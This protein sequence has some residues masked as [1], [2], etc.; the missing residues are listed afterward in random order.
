MRKYKY[1]WNLTHGHRAEGPDIQAIAAG[2]GVTG[3]TAELLANRGCAEFASAD[4]F[5]AKKEGLLHDPFLMRD[6]EP[7]A[8]RILKAVESGEK[9]VVY[10]DYDVDGVTSVSALLLYLKSI[11][12]NA[13]Y[14]I[15]NR[16]GEGYGMSENAVRN[17]ASDGV[18]LVVTVDTGITAVAEAALCRKLGMTLIV[19]DH[20]ECHSDMPDAYAVVN[21]HRP[22]CEY[23]FKELAGVGVVFKLLCALECLRSGDDMYTATKRI[24]ERYIDLVAIGTIADVMPLTDEN[25]LIVSEGLFRIQHTDR[26]GLEALMD[27]V[28]G[29]SKTKSSARK[30]TSGYISFSLA[31]RI[32]AAGRISSAG[33]AVSLFLENDRSRADSLAQ[34]LCEINRERQHE[35]NVIADSASAKIEA[36]AELRTS[37]VIVLDDDSWHHGIIGIVASRITEKYARPSILISFEGSVD[38]EP[39]GDDVGKG[40][41]RSVKGMNLVEALHSCSD[42]LEKYG[43]HELAAGLSVKRANLPALRERLSAFA[44]QLLGSEPQPPSLDYEMLITPSDVTMRQ[45]KELYLLEPFGVANPM[46]VFRMD[47]V[48]VTDLGTVG[49]GKHTKFTLKCGSEYVAAMCFRH[50]PEDYDVYPGD[51]VDVLFTLDVNEFQGHRSLQFIVKDL[52]LTESTYLRE[53]AEADKFSRIIDAFERG[54]AIPPELAHENIP[55]RDD[56]ASVYSLL[57]NELRMEHEQFSIRAL[58]NLMRSNGISVGYIKLRIAILILDEMQLIGAECIDPV[59]EAYKFSYIRTTEKRNLEDSRLMRALRAADV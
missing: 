59:L 18:S 36:S 14:Y 41:G 13:E 1:Q 39:S 20:H 31:P 3:T 51:E 37:P 28:T 23:P 46:P 11:S 5:I 53:C 49:A 6:M 32:N 56:F 50:I 7:C 45:A 21:P 35:E 27:A 2:L 16:I 4:A 24:S 26:P 38:G 22:D 17:F 10:G 47:R 15:P 42:L 55:T 34:K 19:T 52:R 48:P 33:I 43:G 12:A 9:I 40:S 8:R 29:E 54:E 30:I 58:I 44:E 57:R 25:R